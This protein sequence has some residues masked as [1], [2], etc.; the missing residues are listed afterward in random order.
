VGESASARTQR[1][2][3]DLRRAIDRDVDALLARARA[4][5][6]PRNLIR[7]QPLAVLGSL[8]SLATAAGVGITRRARE[9]Q[10]KDGVIDALLDRFGG[11]IDKMKGNARKEFRSQLRKELAEVERTG[12][13]E[14]AYSAVSGAVAA[15]ATTLAAGFAKRLLGDEREEPRSR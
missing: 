4:D 8:V 2:L 11:R 12:P 13:R 10:R 5:L 1:E 9:A 14:A 15:L 7:R 3:A 6:D